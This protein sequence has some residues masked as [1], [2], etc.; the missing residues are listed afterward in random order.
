[1]ARLC[2][3]LARI[4]PLLSVTGL[5]MPV[6]AHAQ[7]T[8][9]PAAAP[10]ADV[11]QAAKTLSSPFPARTSLPVPIFQSQGAGGAAPPAKP[12][13][14]SLNLGVEE[15]ATDNAL[16]TANSRKLDL[17]TS[18]NPSAAV[19]YNGRRV[20]LNANYDLSYDK[21]LNNSTLDGWRHGGMGIFDAEIIDQ[22]LFLDSRYGV[23]ERET[24]STGP[25]TAAA[26]TSATNRTRVTTYSMTPRIEQRL[27]HWAVGQIS[28]SHDETINQSTAKVAPTQSSTGASPAALNNSSGNDA[29]VT[30]RSG[31]AF[32]NLLWDYNGEMLQRFQKGVSG[33]VLTQR[34]HT[35]GLEYRLTDSL[36]V[37]GEFGNDDIQG[38]QIS[39]DVS[40]RFYNSGLH[41]KPS[42]RT[43]IRAGYGARYG[44]NN[45]FFLGERW[46]GQRT[47]VRVSHTTGIT[48]DSMSSIDA[49][50]AVQR[51]E[52]G[53]FV[54]PF[55]GNA[56]NLSTSTPTLSN[57]TFRQDTTDAF[58]SYKT[59]R[60]TFSVD[61]QL[62]K[63]EVIGGG[64][65]TS[66]ATAQGA[67][68]AAT[69]PGAMSTT[70][71]LT[72]GWDH[73][74]GPRTTFTSSV[75]QDEVVATSTPNGKTQ[76]TQAKASLN[77]QLGP[78]VNSYLSY[79]YMESSSPSTGTTG[80]GATGGGKIIENSVIIGLKK[81]F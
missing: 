71:S 22:S 25:S 47:L 11:F 50:N 70:L 37:L 73:T 65:T 66:P 38:N 64:P 55:S 51:D 54:N 13:P 34:T 20:Q 72:L 19:N 49:L 30:L 67:T 28:Y 58:L 7:A 62:L 74:L 46:I 3:Y 44:T 76:R 16:S 18:V 29:K 17:L 45:L 39:S 23:T 63:R 75:G 21:Y 32:S 57:A 53:A 35:L 59:D 68:S 10:A 40:G 78:Q 26:R 24:S 15:K 43:D 6:L 2:V 56:A 14:V 52:T 36:S 60:N 42:D 4:A 81:H 12:P 77:Y 33:S 8:Q 41:W 80:A 79:G 48:T 27:G 31:E 61:S 9:A 5:L 69:A 1:M